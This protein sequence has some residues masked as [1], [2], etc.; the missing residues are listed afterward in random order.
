MVT[1][2]ARPDG[3]AATNG[4]AE[5]KRSTH[6]RHSPDLSWQVNGI[7]PEASHRGGQAMDVD[8]EPED[9]TFD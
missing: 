9:A 1:P 7:V 2:W 5:A 3:I 6:L 8:A 4:R